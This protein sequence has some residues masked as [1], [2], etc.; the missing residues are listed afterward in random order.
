MASA[1]IVKT[2]DVLKERHVHLAS[3]VPSVVPNQF[4]LDDKIYKANIVFNRISGA[5]NRLISWQD[6]ISNPIYEADDSSVMRPEIGRIYQ[7]YAGRCFKA[8]AMDF[9][10]LLLK[11]HELFRDHPDVLNKYQH[12]FHYVMVDEFQDTNI[13]QYQITKKLG[14][15]S[16]NI[17][18]VGDDAQSIYAFRGADIQ[19]ILNFEKDFPELKLIRLEQNYRST[20]NIVNVANSVIANNKAQIQK[21]VWTQN[22]EGELIELLKANSDNEEGRLVASSIFEEKMNKQLRNSDF[23]REFVD[24]K[25]E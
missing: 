23:V 6:Y 15:V 24:R 12:R 16:E 20:K 5:K 14:S 8:T 25:S 17:C 3:G 4:S 18:V 9:D 2:V 1:R 13:C 10:D 22:D 21:A 11:T 19:N 7:A